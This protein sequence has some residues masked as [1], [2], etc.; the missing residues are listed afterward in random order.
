VWLQL[1]PSI[2]SFCTLKPQE[3]TNPQ[4]WGKHRAGEHGHGAATGRMSA[5]SSQWWE[6]SGFRHTSA[7]MGREL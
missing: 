6:G 4:G 1:H 7:G 2:S 5:R 3:G